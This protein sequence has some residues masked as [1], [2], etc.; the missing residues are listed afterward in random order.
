LKPG[1]VMAPSQC[2]MMLGLCDGSEIY[3]DRIGFWE[4]IYGFDLSAMADDLYDEAIVDVVGPDTFLS[5]PY[6][7]KDLILSDITPKELDFSSSFMLVSTAQRRTKINAFVLYFDTFF[8]ARGLPIPPGTEVK[9]IK[10]GEAVLAEL[11][12]VG[13]KP[14]PQRR[15]SMGGRKE[16]ITSFSTGPHSNPTHWKQT[17]F[18]L[19]ES[20]TVSEGSIVVGTFMCRKSEMNARELDVEIHYS[21]KLDEQT[22]PS[23]T[24]VQMYKVR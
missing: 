9:L 23:E 6:P 11:W 22:P 12:P 17:I 7:V 8:T 14:A 15:Q 24:T 1:G 21:V 20:V 4:D 2:Q 13:G 3:K 16:K 18:M 5:K 10:E 19:R